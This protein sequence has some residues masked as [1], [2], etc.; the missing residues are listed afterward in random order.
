M[1]NLFCFRKLNIFSLGNVITNYYLISIKFTASRKLYT[2]EVF[3]VLK[4]NK[5]FLNENVDT[6]LC[7]I[8]KDKCNI[9]NVLTCH[10][11]TK[12][13]KLSSLAKLTFSY[14]E[15]SFTILADTVS[16]L[17]LDF[18]NL[19]KILRSSQLLITTELE[20]YNSANNWLSYNVNE[21][22]KYAKDLL[23]TVRFPLLADSALKYILVKPSSFI[24]INESYKILETIAVNK[25]LYFQNK[26]NTY[27]TTRYC[28][29]QSFDILVCG[30]QKKRSQRI[31]GN[32]KQLNESNFKRINV[33]PSMKNKRGWFSTVC[34]KGEVYVFGGIDDSNSYIKSVEK[35]S[36][37]TNTWEEL[38][39]MCDNRGCHC[40]CLFIDKV[41]IIGGRTDYGRTNSCLQFDIK[42]YSCN[43]VASMKNVRS[44]AA[45]AVFGERIVVSGG[46]DNNLDTLNSVESFDVAADTWSSM[47]R[48]IQARI[49]HSLVVIKEKLFV[50]GGHLSY[51]SCEVFDRICTKFISLKCLVSFSSN[52]AL[53]VGTKIF[54]FQNNKPVIVSYDVDKDDWSEEPCEAAKF[55]YYRSFVKLPKLHIC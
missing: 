41:F 33:L 40:T 34:V 8:V 1:S 32:V 37:S 21:R 6:K 45:C 53:S 15:R 19:V 9:H 38:T 31:V 55:K 36:H 2:N 11:L 16:F 12:I 43:A 4:L 26:S 42:D 49:S 25:E 35:Y 44:S 10:Q 18:I 7:K 13:F 17:E 27:H 23:L 46:M 24:E 5:I 14:I 47:P 28:N 54:I 51:G 3:T 52:K 50:I 39:D 20:V 29:Q 30:N 22:S 48:M